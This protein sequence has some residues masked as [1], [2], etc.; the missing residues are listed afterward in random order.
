M[1]TNSHPCDDYTDHL[2]ELA[3]GTLSGRERADTLGHVETCGRCAAEVE[4]LSKTADE[5]LYVAPETEPPLGFEVRLLERLGVSPTFHAALA[6]RSRRR[7][8]L[9]RHARAVVL[10]AAA[11]VLA[12]VGTGI[13]LAATSGARTPPPLSANGPT[14]VQ[15]TLLSAHGGNVGRVVAT[16]G[17]PPWLFMVIEPGEVS[18]DVTCELRLANGRYVKVGTFW[19]DRGYGTWS[20][21]IQVPFNQVRGARL[22]N[23]AG[24]VLAAATFSG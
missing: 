2:A 21:P 16:T 3:L 19:V 11:V 15:A 17:S 9:A 6:K 10:S 8:L 22:V 7:D 4:D 24:A 12:V 5:L 14:V 13:G 18:G 20:A 1:S 23:G